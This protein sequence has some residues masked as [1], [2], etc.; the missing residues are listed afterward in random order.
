MPWILPVRPAKEFGREEQSSGLG[1]VGQGFGP[2]ARGP[3]SHEGSR[4]VSL[5]LLGGVRERSPPQCVLWAFVPLGTALLS[6]RLALTPVPSSSLLSLSLDVSASL[7]VLPS[8][9]TPWTCLGLREPI[10]ERGG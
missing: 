10:L 6:R 8:P 3:V 4:S 1:R 9:P 5:Q 2:G 7:D